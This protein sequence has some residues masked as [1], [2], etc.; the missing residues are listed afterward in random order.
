ML[1]DEGA[2]LRCQRAGTES[3]ERGGGVGKESLTGRTRSVQEG[4]CLCF[5]QERAGVFTAHV[6][7][8]ILV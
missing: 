8:A 1:L 5:G 4:R 2:V 3:E 7:S 6:H